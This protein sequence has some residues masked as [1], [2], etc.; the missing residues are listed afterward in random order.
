MISKAARLMRR[1]LMCPENWPGINLLRVALM[2]VRSRL[3]NNP[4][5]TSADSV[6]FN[7]E[8]FTGFYGYYFIQALDY[9]QS[10]AVE[11]AD[12]S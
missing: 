6:K 1:L 11:E 7:Q 12:S 5:T 10:T 2:D 3:K 8:N 4:S 9:Q